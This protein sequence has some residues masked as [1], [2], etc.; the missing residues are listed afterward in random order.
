MPGTEDNVFEL[1]VTETQ[2]LNIDWE[3]TKWF[4]FDGN[5]D[6]VEA[7]GATIMHAFAH[8]ADQTGLPGNG[9]DVL[10]SVSRRH[11]SDIRRWTSRPTQLLAGD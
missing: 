10:P 6:V 4:I 5:E 11:S 2:G 8:A 7:R 9:R 1:S 3:R